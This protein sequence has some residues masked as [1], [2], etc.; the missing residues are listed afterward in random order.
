MQE[1]GSNGGRK[2]TGG[3]ISKGVGAETN[4]KN[5]QHWHNINFR[6]MKST[7]RQELP[8]KGVGTGSAGCRRWE[9][10]TPL[11]PTYFCAAKQQGW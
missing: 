3:G 7:Q 4:G 9:V 8:W 2:S 6:N 10:Q 5:L 11:S 1:A